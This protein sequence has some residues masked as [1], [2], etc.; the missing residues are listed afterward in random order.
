MAFGEDQ[1]SKDKRLIFRLVKMYFKN[2]VLTWV[3]FVLWRPREDFGIR[4][5]TI[6]LDDAE[7]WA[8]F[9]RLIVKRLLTSSGL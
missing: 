5:A 7:E 9:A 6:E 2:L 4:Y 3:H 8:T 1:T